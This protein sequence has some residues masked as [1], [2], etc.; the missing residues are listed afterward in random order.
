M[1]GLLVPLLRPSDSEDEP[2]GLSDFAPTA[3]VAR[4][5][6]SLHDFGSGPARRE[7]LACEV[8]EFLV[9]LPRSR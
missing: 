9:F 7:T 2:V 8:R 6:E 3:A 1:P 4:R 5:S